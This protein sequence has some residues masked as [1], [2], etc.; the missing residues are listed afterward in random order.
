[1]AALLV[2]YYI[3]TPCCQAPTNSLPTTCPDCPP[4][5]AFDC[6]QCQASGTTSSTP[7]SRI[8]N[9][10]PGETDCSWADRI[11]GTLMQ[12]GPSGDCN[13]PA[14]QNLLAIL[15]PLNTLT[16]SDKN[17][18]CSSLCASGSVSQ[19]CDCSTGIANWPA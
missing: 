1:M 2:L 8:S 11:E 9:R 6:S 19:W 4:P 13:S 14:K 15:T 5:P 18:V 3:T 10:S 7:F 16:Q 12:T 17:S